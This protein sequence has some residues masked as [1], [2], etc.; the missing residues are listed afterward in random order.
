[1]HKPEEQNTYL[2]L[3]PPP[4]CF[5]REELLYP[6]LG[7]PHS[8]GEE[9][10]F[11]IARSIGCHTHTIAPCLFQYAPIDTAAFAVPF[12]CDAGEWYSHAPAT[13][14]ATLSALQSSDQTDRKYQYEVCLS[15]EGWAPPRDRLPPRPVSIRSPVHLQPCPSAQVHVH[16]PP[17]PS[18]MPMCPVGQGSAMHRPSLVDPP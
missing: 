3:S 10:A 8:T 13:H 16:V 2:P 17:Q 6:R 18:A 1:M 9:H 11:F 4:F 7:S 5:S 15:Y 14:A 12:P